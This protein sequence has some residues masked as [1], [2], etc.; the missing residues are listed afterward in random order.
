M[1]FTIRTVSVS[2]V[3]SA[4]AALFTSF[5][6]RICRLYL[7]VIAVYTVSVQRLDSLIRFGVAGHFNESE[8][9][10]SAGKPVLDHFNTFYIPE[11]GKQGLQSIFGGV[12]G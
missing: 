11:L 4:K 2:I 1:A 6:A 10:W 12:I 3:P 9:L 5:S 8:T 7:N